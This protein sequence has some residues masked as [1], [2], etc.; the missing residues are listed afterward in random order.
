M[1][2]K[3]LIVLISS[4][5]LFNFSV[6]PAKSK[7][8]EVLKLFED[9]QE[10]IISISKSIQPAVVHIEVVHKVNDLK[11]KSLA[12]GLVIDAKGYILT[13]EHVVDKAISVVVTLSS[14]LEYT[15]Q[16]IGTDKQTDLAL[17]K[18]EPREKLQVAKMGNSDEVEVGEW[19]IAVGNPY[20]F[21]R[22]VSFGIVSGK[23]RVLPNLPVETPLINDFIQ[24]D[25]AIDPGSSGGPLVNLKGEVIGINSIGF[26]RAQGFT[27]PINTAKEV[28]EKLLAS[29][30]IN[31]GWLGVVI[32]PLNRD[33]ASYYNSPD[34]EGVI[35][36]DILP[37]SP[38]AKAELLPGDVILEYNHQKISAEKQEDLNRFSLMIS[39]TPLGQVV[40]LKILRDNQVRE[41]SVNIG[42]QPKVEAEE[43]ETGLGFTVKEITENLFRQKMLDDKEGVLV[44]FVDVAGPASQAELDE[45]DII[46]KVDNL[47]IR[48]LD[49]F[50]KAVADVRE[51]KQ[52][53]LVIKRGKAQRFI[54]IL[55]ETK[56]ENKE[57]TTQ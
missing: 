43:F 49:D 19:V 44:S 35:V 51:K 25:A 8:A 23:G 45:G 39:Q 28:N 47:Y 13:N 36:S 12:S 15:A 10:V 56:A 31:R 3:L 27:I 41:I 29:G 42:E 18:I 20:G 33:Y 4:S 57:P 9:L 22:T 37:N 24:T 26:G 50:K 54:L 21:D 11:Y 6:A 38:A 52:I 34:L 40:P 17:L 55:P 2:K 48:T 5:V 46:K 30:R 14:K 1:L 53:M 32:Q 7:P 16:V